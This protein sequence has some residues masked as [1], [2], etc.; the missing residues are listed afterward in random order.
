MPKT[1]QKKLSPIIHIYLIKLWLVFFIFF[2]HC[3]AAESPAW[4]GRAVHD[5][6]VCK[7][8][9]WRK[10]V[11]SFKAEKELKIITTLCI[12]ALR[13][14]RTCSGFLL[15][16]D[17][18]GKSPRLQQVQDK[19]GSFWLQNKDVSPRF[20]KIITSSAFVTKQKVHQKI[21]KKLWWF[22]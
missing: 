7:R 3:E 18:W 17:S 6:G 15:S 21:F 13:W 2:N 19:T 22:Y 11:W 8:K 9:S 12:L 16:D 14:T 5:V 4:T 10:R 1:K 20:T